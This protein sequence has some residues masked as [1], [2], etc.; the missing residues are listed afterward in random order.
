MMEANRVKSLL[1]LSGKT[2]VPGVK[3]TVR[4]KGLFPLTGSFRK[5]PLT[6][7]R[8]GPLGA[9]FMHLVV[10]CSPSDH[11]HSQS[12]LRFRYQNNLPVNGIQQN[13]WFFLRKKKIYSSMAY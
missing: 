7:N 13:T 4:I 3:T 8:P 9:L 1:C 12:I 10:L 5:L 2:G 6:L 11:P